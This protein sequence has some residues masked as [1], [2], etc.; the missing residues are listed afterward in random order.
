MLAV[1]KE[2]ENREKEMKGSKG[3]M[4]GNPTLHPQSS[5]HIQTK[6]ALYHQGFQGE[7]PFTKA[8]SW[9]TFTAEYIVGDG[10]LLH[11]LFFIRSISL[12]RAWKAV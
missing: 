1:I 5:L 9:H 7:M 6:Q 4:F 10:L 3:V 2:R 11:K 8:V 12:I